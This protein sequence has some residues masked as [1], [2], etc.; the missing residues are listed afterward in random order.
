M[1]NFEILDFKKANFFQILKFEKF[2]NA[3]ST[4][5]QYFRSIRIEKIAPI[6]KFK[7]FESQKVE[8]STCLILDTFTFCS[9]QVD[10]VLHMV[11]PKISVFVV[12]VAAVTVV[13]VVVLT[14][15]HILS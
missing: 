4:I 6:Q 7:K 10:L 9:R 1:F 14:A 15:A 5:C 12:F 3:N 8:N 13:V 11:R 2:K